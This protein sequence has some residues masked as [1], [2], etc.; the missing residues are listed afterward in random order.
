MDSLTCRQ[1]VAVYEAKQWSRI[2]CHLQETLGV[3]AAEAE[4]FVVAARHFAAT[5]S[6]PA[7]DP[8]KQRL[9]LGRFLSTLRQLTPQQVGLHAQG[10]WTLSPYFLFVHPQR[11]RRSP[12]QLL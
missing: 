2:D 6:C 11:L 8:G 7:S 1:V 4:D 3:H 9:L 12:C 10:P 5:L